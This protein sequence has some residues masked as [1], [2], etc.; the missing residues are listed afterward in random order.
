MMRLFKDLGGFNM[1]Q[2]FVLYSIDLFSYGAASSFLQ[3][4]W[5][6]KELVLNADLDGY[7]IRP[8]RPLFYLFAKGFVPGYAAHMFLALSTIIVSFHMLGLLSSA[9]AWLILLAAIL[10][11][12][13]IQVGIRCIPALLT[14][15][16]GNVDVLHWIFANDMRSFIMYPLNIYPHFV[17]T[18]FT[19]IL[20]YAFISF[21]PS[22][23]LFEKIDVQ[24]GLSMMLAGFAVAVFMVCLTI[25]MFQRGLRRYESAGG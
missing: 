5:R 12:I 6:M 24:T 1:W 2:V 22:L 25:F 14:F 17:R 3:P 18:I 16:F 9:T 21:Y 4:F 10:T 19:V 7:L 13:G 23:Y 20:P 8:I 11:A 15:W